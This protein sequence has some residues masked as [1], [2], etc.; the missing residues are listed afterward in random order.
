MEAGFI[1]ST[2]VD[3]QGA[4]QKNLTFAPLNWN[5]LN[6]QVDQ[7]YKKRLS[8]L[9]PTTGDLIPHHQQI[10]RSNVF[11]SGVNIPEPD[12]MVPLIKDA[13]VA[14]EEAC[15][16][17]CHCIFALR[18]HWINAF[19]VS[20]LMPYKWWRWV[21]D[22]PLPCCKG[23][24]SSLCEQSCLVMDPSLRLS[25]EELL[26]LPYFGEEVASWGRESERPG[27]RHDKGSRRRQAGVSVKNPVAMDN[28]SHVCSVH[29]YITFWACFITW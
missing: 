19:M 23:L 17:S 10:F 12:T 7:C 1:G 4:L 21:L 8:I 27:R 25:C 3:Q 29:I 11:F 28:K 26:E 6:S 15:V 20:P 18:S 24:T 22:R 13:C 5:Y 14:R 2:T 9:F 16:S